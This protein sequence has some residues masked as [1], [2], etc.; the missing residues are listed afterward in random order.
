M[1][2]YWFFMLGF[3][4]NSICSRVFGDKSAH[5]IHYPIVCFVL[6]VLMLLVG[7]YEQRKTQNSCEALQAK[8][9]KQAG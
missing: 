5:D 2:C 9:E 8:S 7:W 6:L 3:L 1:R 4:F